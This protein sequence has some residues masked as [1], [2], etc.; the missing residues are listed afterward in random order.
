MSTETSCSYVTTGMT[1]PIALRQ[2]VSGRP[3]VFIEPVD[4]RVDIRQ[5]QATCQVHFK[6]DHLLNPVSKITDAGPQTPGTT[7]Q[8]SPPSWPVFVTAGELI[9]TTSGTLA[10]S[11]DFG[12]YNTEHTNI[13]G[14]NQRYIDNW[15]LTQLESVCPYDFFEP[16]KKSEYY[17]LFG[18]PAGPAGAGSTCRNASRDVPGTIAG[19]WFLDSGYGGDYGP[20]IALAAAFDGS[21]RIGGLGFPMTI[22]SGA[23]DPATITT[24]HCYYDGVGH[25]YF[26]LVTDLLVDVY[27]GTGSCPPSFPGSGY[28]TY[29]R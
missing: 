17:A 27:Y 3:L 13:F 20:Q 6:F 9:G 14:N 16:T 22:W 19:A 7:T 5:T 8:T 25:A 24:E 18:P 21:V 10:H 4:P 28:K 12:A 2:T 15:W 26:R 23:P 1:R 29:A 11:W